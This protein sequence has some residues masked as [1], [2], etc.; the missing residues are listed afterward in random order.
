[1]YLNSSFYESSTLELEEIPI[2]QERFQAILKD[3]L[4]KQI[5]NQPLLFPWEVK[6]WKILAPKSSCKRLFIK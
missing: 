2:I 5:E 4:A 3:W 1:M 6:E